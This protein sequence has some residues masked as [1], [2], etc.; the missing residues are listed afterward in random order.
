MKAITY[1]S[2]GNADVLTTVDEPKPAVQAGEVL[3]R[4]K[5]VSINPMD[6][7]IRKGEMKLMSGSKFPRHTGVDFAG[8]VEDKGSAVTDLKVGDPVFGVVKNSM[9]DGALSEYVVVPADNLWK[10]P[11]SLSFAQAASLPIVGAAAITAFRRMGSGSSKSTILINGATGG[12]GMILLQL[13]RR[14][15]ARV[16]AVTGTKN[17][18]HAKEWGADTVI[19]YTTTDVRRQRTTYDIIVDLSGK[20]PYARAKGIMAKK[21]LYLDATPQPLDILTSPFRNLFRTK[22]HVIILAAPAEDTMQALLQAVQT[23]LDITVSRVF[24]FDRAVEAYRYAERGGV[25]GKVVI[26]V[27]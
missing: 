1:R 3:V 24:P 19:D 14:T 5:S 16:T 9:K 20:L 13:L 7:K 6:W 2:F 27:A 17:L 10:K 22:K 25:A 8:T 21:A 11:E 18:A 15:G 26:E 12:F 23:G 4:V